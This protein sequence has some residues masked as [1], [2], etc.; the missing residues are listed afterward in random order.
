MHSWLR[1][2]AACVLLGSHWCTLKVKR[3]GS[4]L[5]WKRSS[6][7]FESWKGLLLMTDV[8]TTSAEA[9]LRVMW[10]MASAQVVETSVAKNSTSLDSENGFCT[11]YRNIS[12]QQQSFSGLHSPWRS[13]PIKVCYPCVQTIFLLRLSNG[14]SIQFSS[15]A[16]PVHALPCCASKSQLYHPSL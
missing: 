11:G 3:N 14:S 6:G 12:H 7:W 9:I 13:F 10:K 8:S 4:Y 15:W 5:D 16:L 1:S 2:N